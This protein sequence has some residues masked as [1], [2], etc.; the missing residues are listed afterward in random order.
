MKPGEKR[1][2]GNKINI[3]QVTCNVLIQFAK[4]IQKFKNSGI[5]LQ[6]YYSIYKFTESKNFKNFKSKDKKI[7]TWKLKKNPDWIVHKI[8]I[9]YKHKNSTLRQDHKIL[10]FFDPFPDKSI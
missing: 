1:T 5:F 8:E 2:V 4:Y 9:R 10:Y 3:I 7:Y 6:E